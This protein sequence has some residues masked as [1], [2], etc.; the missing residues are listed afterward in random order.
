MIYYLFICVENKEK[1]LENSEDKALRLEVQVDKTARRHIEAE[2]TI[3]EIVRQR[4]LDILKTRCRLRIP[5]E[6][7]KV[8]REWKTNTFIIIV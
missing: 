8:S 3:E 6:M 5:A 2:Y 4:T 7:R 1:A